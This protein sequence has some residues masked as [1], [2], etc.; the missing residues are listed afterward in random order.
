MQSMRNLTRTAGFCAVALGL[1]VASGCSTTANQASQANQTGKMTL[2]AVDPPKNDP[3]APDVAHC[4][5]VT[6]SSPVLYACNGK[7]YS[8]HQL[9]RLRQQQ[10]A[11]QRAAQQ[12]ATE[13][14]TKKP[15]PDAAAPAPNTQSNSG[16]NVNSSAVAYSLTGTAQLGT[17]H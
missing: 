8:E 12:K 1:V 5:L 4:A 3:S 11:Q 14:A 9:A 6:I 7:T 17:G 10:A 15:A 16:S 2:A 13:A